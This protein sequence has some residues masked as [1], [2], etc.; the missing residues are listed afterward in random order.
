MKGSNDM[1]ARNNHFEAISDISRAFGT[2]LDHDELLNLI[3]KSAV[4]AMQAK[5]ACLFLSTEGENDNYVSVAQTG[6]SKKCLHSE[7]EQVKQIQGLLK[8]EGHIHY[9]DAV[10]DPRVQNRESK[11]KEGIVSILIVPVIVKGAMIGCL[12]LYTAEAKDFSGKEIKFLT[13]LA[14][15]GGIAVE[16][17]RLIRK[18]RDNT[19]IFLE[20]ATGI[21]SSLE[22]LT[23]LQMLTEDVAKAIGVK[24]ATIR[25][26]DDNR[27]TLRLAASYG[28]SEKY[29]NKGP[30]SAEKSIAEALKGKPVVVKDARKDAGVQYRNEKK[31]EEIVSIL[32]VPIKSK[33]DVIGVLRLYS[34]R[35][36]NFSD[37]EIKFVMALACLGGVAIQNAHFITM[38]KTDIKELRSE[39][40]IFNSW[41]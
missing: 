32:C 9:R 15:Q 30:I 41:F 22:I 7:A 1:Q 28:L 5:A 6:L 23:I 27:K 39:Q 26:L 4:K 17:T 21:A 35:E 13:I 12:A 36:R 40:W 33:E 29:L 37:D 14:E 38:L 25:F 19:R 31:D 10:T 11:K 8:K 34:D 3:V 18:M 24:A 20:L 2:T 16:N